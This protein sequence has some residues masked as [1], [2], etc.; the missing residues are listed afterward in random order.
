MRL[1]V[2]DQDE[3]ARIVLADDG[4]TVVVVKAGLL[5]ARAEAVMARVLD[6]LDNGGQVVAYPSDVLIGDS[7]NEST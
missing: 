2:E 5:P 3:D 4:A 7:L 1:Q 6:L